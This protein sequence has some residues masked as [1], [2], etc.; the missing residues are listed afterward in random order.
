MAALVTALY[1]LILSS[2]LVLLIIESG[3]YPC[4]TFFVNNSV[5]VQE[6][7]VFKEPSPRA[8]LLVLVVCSFTKLS[9]SKNVESADFTNR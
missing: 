7:H 8:F 2:V 1:D 9:D 3:S 6:Y 4:F 5:P